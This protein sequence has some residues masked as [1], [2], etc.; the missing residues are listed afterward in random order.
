MTDADAIH[1]T[2]VMPMA[3]P[4]RRI[5]RRNAEQV[6]TH[7]ITPAAPSLLIAASQQQPTGGW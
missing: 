3:M 2:R 5:A 7:N 1:V 4:Q 6:V